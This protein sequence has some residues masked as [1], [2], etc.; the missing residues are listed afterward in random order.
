[1]TDTTTTEPETAVTHEAPL[2]DYHGAVLAKQQR[3]LERAALI[4]VMARGIH[5]AGLDLDTP[6]G[7]TVLQT[8]GYAEVAPYVDALLDSPNVVVAVEVSG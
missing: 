8:T 5:G 7:M 1:M 6:I 4:D 2:D 3:A